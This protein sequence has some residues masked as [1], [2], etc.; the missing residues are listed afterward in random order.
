[1]DRELIL[2]LGGTRVLGVAEELER[3]GYKALSR[4]SIMG[5]MNALRHRPVA[6]ILIDDPDESIDLL[7]LVLNVRDV[8]AYVPV[9]V[10]GDPAHH[11]EYDRALAA[12]PHVFFLR[13]A[14]PPRR[15]VAD[16]VALME[17]D[18]AYQEAC[19]C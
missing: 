17:R 18:P 13:G 6:W 5:A 7:E 1:M 8:D 11:G 16:L 12:C 2:V 19:E 9:V 15:V 3:Q 4:T 14:R 10:V